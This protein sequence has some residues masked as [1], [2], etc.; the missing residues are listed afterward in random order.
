MSGTHIIHDRKTRTSAHTQAFHPATSFSITTVLRWLNGKT[1][2]ETRACDWY[3]ILCITIKC[4]SL[5]FR[6]CGFPP[7]WYGPYSN[8]GV[9][10]IGDWV[11]RVA[12]WSWVKCELSHWLGWYSSCTT[13]WL[14]ASSRIQVVEIWERKCTMLY[15]MTACL[16]LCTGVCFCFVIRSLRVR[17]FCTVSWIHRPS[18]VSRAGAYFRDRS[19]SDNRLGRVNQCGFGVFPP[20]WGPRW[21][22]LWWVG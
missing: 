3:V 15:R 21:W 11:I 9:I 6:L 7:Y 4:E 13:W 1:R 10:A 2:K 8:R 18:E 5:N 19:W 16:D 20:L 14:H 12:S 17:C 22:L